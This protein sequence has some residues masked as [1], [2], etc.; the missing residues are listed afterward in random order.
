MHP[1]MILKRARTVMAVIALGGAGIA[2]PAQAQE[3]PAQPAPMAI[4]DKNGSV[5]ISIGGQSRF[6]M[7]TKR[8]IK[9]AFNENDKIV[10]VLADASDPSTLILIGRVPGTSRLDLTDGNGGKESYLIVVDSEDE[11][12]RKK[13]IDELRELIRK[14]VPTASVEITPILRPAA[15]ATGSTAPDDQN[16]QG[17]RQGQNRSLGTIVISGYAAQEGDRDT[18]QNLASAVGLTVAVNNVTVGGGG[19]VP[20]VQLDLTLAKVD[21]TRARSRGAN[22]IFSGS[23]FSAGSLLGGLTSLQGGSSSTASA[24]TAGVG[25]L[26]SPATA[27]ATSSANLIGGIIPSNIQLLLAALKTEGLAKLVAAPTVVARSGEEAQLLVGG[28]VPV[29]GAAAGITGPGVTYRPVGTELRFTPIVYGNGKIHL[30][31]EPR[32]TSVN[33]TQALTT[34][35]GTSPAFDEQRM[36]TSVVCEPGQTIAIGGL[37]QTNSQGTVTKIPGLGDIPYLGW[38]FSYA[39]QT[40]EE[41]ELV[42]LVTPRL[43]DPSDSS[44]MPK[45]LPGSETRKPDDFEFYLETILEAPRGQRQIWDGV[46]YKAAWKSSPTSSTYPCIGGNCGTPAGNC[47]TGNC[48]AP[49]TGTVV[50]PAPVRTLPTLDPGT[51]VN[52]IPPSNPAPVPM[53]KTTPASLPPLSDLT[54]P[55]DIPIPPAG[56]VTLA[57]PTIS[58]PGRAMV[59]SPVK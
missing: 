2:F 26:A 44:Q 3:R 11:A 51:P 33:N 18:I 41:I 34:S 59:S 40:D 55:A 15:R 38:A 45:P 48:A 43:I 8:P 37:I 4:F 57:E 1:T 49:V 19:N 5:I 35:F 20:H 21:R 25:V 24:M 50:S 27:A 14:T 53:L 9:E 22:L 42:I 23:T 16:T 32:V 36:T 30:T 31:V 54:S 56:K 12:L 6:Q 52:V 7:R 29:I 47:A 39:T 13:A 10:Q 28:Q 17:N 58:A 46:H